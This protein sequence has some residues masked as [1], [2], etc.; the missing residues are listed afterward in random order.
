MSTPRKWMHLLTSA[1]LAF[2][3][4]ACS[5]I[6]LNDSGAGADAGA[7]G[8][9]GATTEA[10]AGSAGAGNG[11]VKGVDL[12]DNQTQSSD[13]AEQLDKVVYFDFDSYVLKDEFAPLIAAHARVLS[14]D[15]TL[16]V[17]LA[18]H[19]DERGS[20]EYNLALGQQRAEAV[21]RALLLLGA[22][23]LQVEA[24]SYGE[25]KPASLGADEASF[26][27]NRRVEINYR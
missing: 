19:T 22:Q 13:A 9:A 1:A 14:S 10:G 25:E 8:D 21:K 11:D 7:S 5:S 20:R 23:E 24:I 16:R 12:G 26:A 3:L 17:V 4:A 15:R 27:A 18:G 2:S 6:D